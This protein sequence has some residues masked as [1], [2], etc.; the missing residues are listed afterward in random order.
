MASVSYDALLRQKSALEQQGESLADRLNKIDQFYAT[1]NPRR[2]AVEAE[3]MGNRPKGMNPMFFLSNQLN[4][5]FDRLGARN[6]AM[7]DQANNSAEI[8]K[9]LSLL[10]DQEQFDKEYGLKATEGGVAFDKNGKPVINQTGDETLMNGYIDQLVGGAKIDDI[11]AEDRSRVVRY[12]EENN[13]D[14]K[15]LQKQKEGSAIREIVGMLKTTYEGESGTKD[16]LS[17]GRGNDVKARIQD[18]ILGNVDGGRYKT[19]RDYRKGIAGTLKSVVGETGILTDADITRIT[20]LM[21]GTNETPTEAARKWKE[22]E[23]FLNGRYGGTPETS[24]GTSANND[25]LGVR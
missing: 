9:V 15:K 13:I 6:N 14:I 11:P 8:L 24:S 7:T 23:T 4:E 22:L 17:K 12:I 16:D 1:T 2:A 10:Q 18:L 25:P 19:Y 3:L 20:N 21:P 5:G